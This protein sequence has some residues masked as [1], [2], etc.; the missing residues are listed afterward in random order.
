MIMTEIKFTTI[1]FILL[2][3]C[4]YLWR[5]VRKTASRQIDFYDLTML[6]A[7]AVIPVVFVLFPSFSYK[8]AQLVGVAFPFV[9][10]FGIL[11]AVL[12]FFVHRLTV[13]L[14]RIE[15]ESRL[16]IQE[17]SL[18]KQEQACVKSSQIK[19]GCTK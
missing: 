4:L 1:C 2:F 14:H 8:L 6:S 12:F 10:L 7:V 16:L 5:I 18:L 19:A 3:A 17:V 13:K 11:L 9:I 15:N